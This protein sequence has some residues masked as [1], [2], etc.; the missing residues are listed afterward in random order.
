MTEEV[1][2]TDA[3]QLGKLAREVC[4]AVDLAPMGVAIVALDG[5]LL[6]ANATLCRWGGVQRQGSSP[7]GGLSATGDLR[8]HLERVAGGEALSYETARC[9]LIPGV[10]GRFTV[11]LGPLR[12]GERVVAGTVFVTDDEDR[13]ELEDQPMHLR[14]RDLLEGAADGVIVARGNVLLYANRALREWL[15][16][17]GPEQIVGQLLTELFDAPALAAMAAA[18]PLCVGATLRAAEGVYLPVV[19]SVARVSLPE[20]L[21]SIMILRRREGEVAVGP[22]PLP[23]GAATRRRGAVL[24]CDDESRLAM[25]TAG[26]LEQHGF[27]ALTVGTGEAALRA[28]LEQPIDVMLLDLN[29][30]DGNA[31]EVIARMRELSLFRPVILTSGYAEED[32]EPAL[33]RSSTVTGYLAKPYSVDRLIT[34]IEH[35]M[36]VREAGTGS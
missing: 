20:G 6:A 36:E 11:Q 26:L 27:A 18:P 25:L 30:P 7:V 8:R 19:V 13:L 35:A 10:R 34:A 29:L 9:E 31:H 2:V 33:L 4:A 22:D 5:T 23:V 32:V 15:G 1:G 28:M 17:G 21:T 16:R 12:V 3:R 24:V 14:F